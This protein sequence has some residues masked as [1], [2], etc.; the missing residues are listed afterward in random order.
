AFEASEAL[1]PVATTLFTY[2]FKDG[3]EWHKASI[4]EPALSAADCWFLLVTT[5]ERL[6]AD[7]WCADN[8]LTIAFGDSES[9]AWEAATALMF[10]TLAVKTPKGQDYRWISAGGYETHFR[11]TV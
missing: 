8:G 10:R 1:S 9:A 11:E 4:E 6:S 7:R 5:V 2:V 3:Q